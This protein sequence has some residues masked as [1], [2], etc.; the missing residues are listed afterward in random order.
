MDEGEGVAGEGE[1]VTVRVEE[2]G[3]AAVLGGDV[4][5]VGGV[6][7]DLEDPVPV[8]VVVVDSGLAGQDR[9]DHREEKLRCVEGRVGFAGP[10]REGA[11]PLQVTC[12]KELVRRVEPPL[13][14]GSGSATF[15]DGWGFGGN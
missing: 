12:A 2:E 7:E 6:T 15:H 1:G 13:R 9:V 14:F 3:E 10:N 11:C 4:V 8:A 5:D